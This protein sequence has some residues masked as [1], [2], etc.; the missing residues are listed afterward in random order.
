MEQRNSLT[1]KQYGN[2]QNNLQ[3]STGVPVSDIM[4]FFQGDGLEKQLG[5]GEQRGGNNGCSGCGGDSH[6]S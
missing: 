2:L 6:I 1:L 5:R 3:T 4:P